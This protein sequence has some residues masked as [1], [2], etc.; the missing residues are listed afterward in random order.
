MTNKCVDLEL[1]INLIKK[2]CDTIVR[3]HYAYN[4][5]FIVFNV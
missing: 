5:I 1:K 3:F 2:H 4:I